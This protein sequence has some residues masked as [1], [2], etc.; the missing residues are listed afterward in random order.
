YRR[1]G[2]L[3]E[4]LAN[5]LILLG[6]MPRDGR[7]VMPPGEAVKLFEISEMNDVQAKFDIQKLRWLNAEYIVKAPD[8]RLVPLLKQHLEAAGIPSASIPDDYLARI[9]ALYRVRIKTLSEF[10]PLTDCFF[11]DDVAYDEDGR[12]HLESPESREYLSLLADRLAGLTDFAHAAI[13]AVFRAF[14][15]ERG[16]KIG[17]IVHPARMAISGKTKGAGLFEMMEVLGRERVVARMRRAA[18]GR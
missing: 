9:L 1:E 13:E 10:P 4:A 5:Y 7:E 6:W 8:E 3:P 18:H 11:R 14:A 17:P 2:F 12:K 16:I 15:E